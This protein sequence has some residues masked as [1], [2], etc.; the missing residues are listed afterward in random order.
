MAKE[1]LIEKTIVID[2]DIHEVFSFLKETKN[3]D[4]FSVWNMKDPGM[5]KTYTGEDGTKGFIYAWDSKDRNVGAGEQEIT[6]I[7]EDTRIDYAIRF[8]RPMKNV[9]QSGFIVDKRHQNSTSVTWNFVSPTKFPMSLFAPI[10]K[11]MLGKQID[12]G[13]HNLKTLLEKR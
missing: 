7:E 8:Q 5:K 9:A 13:L 10:F 2:K 4:K 6:N 1:M 12:E 11:K 3:Q